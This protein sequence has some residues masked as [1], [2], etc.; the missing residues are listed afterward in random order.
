MKNNDRRKPEGADSQKRPQ[1]SFN[2]AKLNDLMKSKFFG[3]FELTDAIRPAP[4]SDIRPLQGYRHE[5]YLDQETQSKVPVVMA[6]AGAKLVFPLFLELIRRLGPVVDVVLESSHEGNEGEHVDMY[7]ESIDMPVLISILMEYED[8][9]VND[10]CTGIAVLNPR[11]PQEIQFEEHKLLIVYG[12]PLEQFEY[13]LERHGVPENQKMKLITEGEHVHSSTEAYF[14][15]FQQLR[16]ELGLDGN[17][18][19]EQ[20]ESGGEQVFEETFDDSHD[21][22]YGDFGD[23]WRDSYGDD[24]GGLIN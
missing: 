5:V 18:E 21:Q 1:K 17:Q 9:L 12:S 10:G 13:L 7:R 15:R 8:L 14:R 3:Q 11:T 22:I 16:V 19:K 6:S 20:Y 4:N 24:D 23:H 2:E